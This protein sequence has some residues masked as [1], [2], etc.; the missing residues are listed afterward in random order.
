MRVIVG[1]RAWGPKLNLRVESEF[2]I[3]PTTP[4]ND[5]FSLEN[6][7]GF[8]LEHDVIHRIDNIKSIFT[9][10]FIIFWFNLLQN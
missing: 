10:L 7:M 2:I 3:S 4:E 8:G 6:V 5:H 9:I 1:L